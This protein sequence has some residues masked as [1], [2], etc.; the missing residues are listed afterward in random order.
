MS[1]PGW[2]ISDIVPI[3]WAET[4]SIEVEGYIPLD[5]DDA[6]LQKHLS[7]QHVARSY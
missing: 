5:S 2:Y 7:T 1:F 3:L 4:S 6:I